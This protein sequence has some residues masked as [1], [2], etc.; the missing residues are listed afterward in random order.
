[1][2]CPVTFSPIFAP[3]RAKQKAT[4]PPI[5]ILD[6]LNRR[7]LYGV[8]ML[9]ISIRATE[10]NAPVAGSRI[11]SPGEITPIMKPPIKKLMRLSNPCNMNRKLSDMNRP[12]TISP[13]IPP[14]SSST[15][16]KIPILANI[17]LVE[18]V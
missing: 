6:R 15:P 9:R 8:K 2:R 16:R 7:K 5:I 14:M 1:M 11:R 12:T 10:R 4:A 13:T 3:V 17:H 18:K